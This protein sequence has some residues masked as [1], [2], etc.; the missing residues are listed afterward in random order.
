M[1]AHKKK[2][3]GGGLGELRRLLAQEGVS[4]PLWYEASSSREMGP[5]ARKA[6]EHGANFLFIWGGDG[7]VQRCVNEIADDDVTVA[8]LP[9]GT[10]NLLASNL[11]I[12]RDLKGA[13]D[14][15][16]NGARRRLDL[17]VLN[18]DRFSV[19]A[20]VGFDAIMMRDADMGLKD[21]FGRL[22]YVWTASRAT[23]MKLRRI[24]IKVDGAVWFDGRASCVLLGQMGTLAGGVVAFPTAKPDDGL[25]E[26]GV[27]TAETRADWLRVFTRMVV[28]R[29]DRSPL[30]Q[31]TQGHNVKI[32][33]DRP[34]IYELDGG[35]RKKTKRLTASIQPLAITICVPQEEPT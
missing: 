13:V 1:I 2:T 3:L 31:M 11:K 28:G 14:I 30:T 33:L 23:R 9:A 12:P 7:S 21:R 16:F 35:V 27:V 6:I 22:A 29:A 15:G 19:M 8:L 17:G 32:K 4:D 34:T 26:I 20:G 10:A 5:L 18:G 25:L 24:R